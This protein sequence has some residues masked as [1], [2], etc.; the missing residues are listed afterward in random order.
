VGDRCGDSRAVR[1]NKKSLVST[2]KT[3]PG[4]ILAALGTAVIG[5]LV[6]YFAPGALDRLT[7]E[8]RLQVRLETNPATIDSFTGFSHYALVPRGQRV[9]GNPGEGCAG[10]YPWISDFGGVPAGETNFR[11]I[12]QGGGDQTHIGGI[13]ARV[14]ER[15]P[16]LSGTGFECPTQAGLKVRPVALDLDEPN[17]TGQVV[18]YVGAE[19]VEKSK[20]VSF[21]VSEDE[22]EVFDISATTEECY[23]E[24]ILELVTTQDGDQEI[25]SLPEGGSPLETTAWPAREDTPSGATQVTRPYYLYDPFESSWFISRASGSQPADATELPELSTFT[26][27]VR[28]GP[29]FHP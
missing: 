22:T 24:W 14:I 5:A 6:A 26:P 25:I 19:V 7:G 4:A 27:R 28:G 20:G 8:D 9:S 16:P 13:R 21:T 12:A 2:L 1:N 11:V 17:P 10:F 29:L 15:N 18:E 3:L 23:C